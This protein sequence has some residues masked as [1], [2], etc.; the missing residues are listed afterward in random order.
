MVAAEEELAAAIAAGA[1]A[2][3]IKELEANLAKEK[4]EAEEAAANA[5]KERLEQVEAEAE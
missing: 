4:A 2:E 5:E 3:R 1:E